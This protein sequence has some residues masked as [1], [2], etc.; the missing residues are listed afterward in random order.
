MRDIK[1]QC[2][3]NIFNTYTRTPVAFVKGDGCRLWDDSGKEYLDF[4]AGIA[5][6]NLGHCHPA[7]TRAIASSAEE[8]VHVSNLFY[9]YP[10]VELAAELTRLS[11]ADKVFFSNS[12]AEAN[13]AAIKLARKYSWDHFGPG[14]F[15]IIT[16]KNSFHGRTLAT[17]SATGQSKVHNGFEPLVEGF[18]YVDFNSIEAVDAAITDKTCAVLVE[19]VQGEGGLNFASPWYFRELR[20]LCVKKNL[21]LIFDEVQSGLGRT[22]SLFAYEQEGITP[23]VMTLAKAL[24]NGLPMGAMLATEEAA[25]AFVP[26]THATT[27][28]GGPLV[29]NAALATLGILSN[30]DFLNGV[31]ETGAY[32]HSRLGELKQRYPFIKEVRGRGLMMGIEL[33]IPGAPFVSKCLDAGVIINCTHETVLRFV[34]PL[35]AGRPEVDRLIDVLNG[36]FEREVK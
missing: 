21:L 17:L 13:E 34:P 22:G 5:V 14:R 33:D 32:L 25:K 10:Q 24:A 23:D 19:P 8:L 31:R 20:A 27:F 2:H 1:Q 4:L 28:G 3:E 7:V 18:T 6:C 9:T 35:I 30:P 36:I 12:G 15:H 11:F 16:M 26:G 29:A